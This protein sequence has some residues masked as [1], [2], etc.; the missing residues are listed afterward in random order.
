MRLGESGEPHGAVV[1]A[2]EQTAGRGRAGRSWASEKSSGIYCSVLL[3]P[4][5]PPAHAPLLTLIA[6]LAARDAAAEDLERRGQ[7]L[8][9]REHGQGLAGT[10]LADH[11]QIVPAPQPAA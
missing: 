2:E 1:L 11:A 5:I 9:H 10:A 6:G 8:E 4:P 3:R 7:E